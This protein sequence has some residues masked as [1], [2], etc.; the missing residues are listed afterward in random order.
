MPAL[1]PEPSIAPDFP[2]EI[3]PKFETDWPGKVEGAN[4]RRAAIASLAVH[5]AFTVLLLSLP[6]DIWQSEPRVAPKIT[7]TRLYTPADITQRDPNKGKISKSF[8]E[9]S[10]VARDRV[11][12]PQSQPSRTQPAA[13]A[14]GTPAPPSPAPSP[15][16]SKIETPQIAPPPPAPRGPDPQVLAQTQAPQ[17][18]SQEKLP[19][20]PKLAFEN[21]GGGFSNTD[22]RGVSRL[23]TPD[24]SVTGA[25]RNTAPGAARGASGGVMVGDAF[26]SGRGGLGD[27]LNAPAGPGKMGSNLE[28]LSDPL[29][30]DFRPYLIRV[31]Q[32]VKVNWQAVMPESARMGR[33]GRVSIQFSID[34]S[35]NVPKL[36]IVSVSGADALDRAAVAGI[37]A[38][39]PFPPLPDEFK[40][41]VVRLQLNF[42]YNLPAQ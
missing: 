7:I 13:K 31:L 20:K 24:S 19:E 15:Q 28:L 4:V 18:Q 42:A 32:S 33:R 40:G 23:P 14:P 38:S 3:L 22:S 27:L 2:A 21:V 11:Q 6:K 30:V 16:P 5:F 41:S 10:L 25:I 8:N 34:R 26:G 35:G 39:N 29:G 37:S 12:I 1:S 36:V 17:I 9:E